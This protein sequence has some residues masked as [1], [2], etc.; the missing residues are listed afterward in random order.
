MIKR[1]IAIGDQREISAVRVTARPFAT[2]LQW[3]AS[4]PSKRWLGNARGIARLY[5]VLRLHDLMRYKS[6]FT[7]N[8]TEYATFV[9]DEEL[10]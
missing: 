6:K 2:P 1:Q 5:M 3:R 9:P 7:Y 8:F 10:F 4:D